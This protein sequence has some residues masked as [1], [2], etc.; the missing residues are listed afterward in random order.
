MLVFNALLLLAATSAPASEG[1]IEVK[2]PVVDPATPARTFDC[3]LK[4][5]VNIDLSKDQKPSDLMLAGRFPMSLF[6]P[7]ASNHKTDSYM[8]S[9]N[10]GDWFGKA[11]MAFERV[12]DSWPTHVELAA[13]APV[14]FNFVILNSIDTAAGT[15]TISAGRGINST[16][17]DPSFYFQ[18]SCRFTVLPAGSKAP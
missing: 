7:S 18:G 11:P 8:L 5:I 10:E 1:Q 4:R 16:G 14:G 6:M 3:E 13:A 9:A 15:A 12:S 17:I 2:T